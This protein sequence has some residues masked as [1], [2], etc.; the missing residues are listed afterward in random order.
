MKKNGLIQRFREFWAS[1][2][3]YEQVDLWDI[4]SSLRGED[5]GTYLVKNFTTARIRGELLGKYDDSRIENERATI[6]FSCKEV[7]EYHP[8]S[9]QLVMETW[10]KADFHFKNHVRMAIDSLNK[11]VPKSRIRDLQKFLRD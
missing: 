3:Q 6:F 1:L 2:D 5:D 7:N 11:H 10:K 9:H 8:H 4:L